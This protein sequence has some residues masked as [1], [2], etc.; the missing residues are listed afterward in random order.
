MA[1]AYSRRVSDPPPPGDLTSAPD[2]HAPRHAAEA[3]AIRAMLVD[4]DRRGVHQLLVTQF[5]TL[6]ARAGYVL[7]FC[8]VVITTTGFSGRLIAGTNAAAQVCIIAGVALVMLA[9]WLVLVAVLRVRWTTQSLQE[10]TGVDGTPRDPLPGLLARR[11]RRTRTLRI[12][13][14]VA[15]VGMSFY[16][17]AIAIMLAYPRV[18]AIR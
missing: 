18:D 5:A 9:A 6:Q 7:T 17:A 13:T 4:P 1:R 3:A 8:G 14:L 10:L 2:D 15:M 11:D 16:V 12:A